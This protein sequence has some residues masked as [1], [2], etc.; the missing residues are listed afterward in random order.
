MTKITFLLQVHT[1]TALRYPIDIY[2]S[3][4]DIYHKTTFLIH[5]KLDLTR[6]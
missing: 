6:C 1:T 4:Y 3:H 2:K 5:S